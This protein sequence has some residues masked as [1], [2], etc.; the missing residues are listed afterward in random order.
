[1]AG[2]IP[3][4][5]GNLQKLE[6]LGLNYNRLT[7]PI[8]ASIFNMSSLQLFTSTRTNLSGELAPNL[9]KGMPN[10]EA[11]YLGMNNLTGFL[12]ASISNASKLRILD[13]SNNSFTGPIP[14]TLGNL[15]NLELLNLGDNKFTNPSSSDLTFLTSLT[16]CRHLNELVIAENPLGGKL[17]TTI[18]NFSAN[19]TIFAAYRCMI[20]GEIPQ[21][22]GSVTNLAMLSLFDNE[23]KGNIPTTIA[24]LHKLQQL[25]LRNNKIVGF[26][27]S[28]FC[29]LPNLGALDL[30]QNQIYG[31]VPACLGDITSL[32]NLY[33]DS[34]RL[35]STLPAEIWSLKNLLRFNAS[36]N[37]LYGNLPQEIGNLKAVTLIDLSKNNFTGNIPPTIGGLQ[38]L[39]YLSLANNRLEGPVPDSLGRGLSLESLDLSHN[40]LTGEVPKS[41][42]ALVYLRSLDVSFNKLTGEIP[43]EGPFL[44]FTEQSF[45]SNEALC[46]DSRF[47]VP[48]CKSSVPNR[49]RRKR[50]L[51]IALYTLSG[52][53]L[54]SIALIGIILFKCQKKRKD[55]DQTLTIPEVSY[56]R[57][58]YHELQEATDG[59]SESNTLGK[60]GFGSVYKGRL[61]D[62]TVVAVKVFN[63]ESEGSYKSFDVECKAL[64]SLRHRNLAKVISSCSNTEFRALVLDYMPNGSLE[65]WLYS[66]NYFLN[67]LQRVNIVI[68]VA[69][70]LDYLHNEFT[71][72]VVHC[73]LKPSNVLLD[74]EFIAHVSDF[75]I[76]KTLGAGE[77][78][79]RTRTMA[80]IGYIAP[81]DSF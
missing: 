73:D 65:K 35:N 47:Q 11:L 80:T 10:L 59:F 46:G 20:H 27:P 71:I 54:V 14:Y 52:F 17:P 51:H 57:I 2:E 21:E 41:L 22:I 31:A 62:G 44:N 40:Y 16:R 25:Y 23:L 34:N 24:R 63:L 58:S 67:I 43:N 70:A 38:S 53:G 28:E 1:M 6:V 55:G 12:P 39:I 48:K 66:H 79:A 5:I 32:R 72:H 33:L 77:D 15:E 50:A 78:A 81:G 74:E 42:V 76:S 29:S 13:L 18:G 69:C 60:G 64:R 8:P 56:Q 37:M 3:E 36:S 30:S 45:M 26:I 19:L 49:P 75:G 4:E 68:D 61:K 9:G 7:G